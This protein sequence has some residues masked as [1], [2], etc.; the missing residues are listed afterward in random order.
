MSE[1][2]LSRPVE[3]EASGSF[4]VE[5][6][7]RL[8]LETYVLALT[9]LVW[10]LLAIFSPYFWTAGN[11]TNILRQVSIDAILAFGSLFP[12]ILAGIDLSVGSV[13]GLSGVVFSMLIA[14]AGQGLLVAFIATMAMGVVIGVIN[15]WAIDR[16]GIPPFIVTLAGLQGYRGLA[17]LL[18]GG[19]TI[20]GMPAGLQA[21][22]LSSVAHV[23]TLFLLMAVIGLGAHFLLAYTRLG[24]YMYAIGSNAEAA[25]RVGI[26]VIHV[27]TVA[28]ALAAGFATLSGLLLVARLSMGSPTAATG[29]ELQAIAAAV[30]G[31]ASLFGGRGTILGCFIGALLFTTIG[32]GANLLGVNSFWQMVIEGLLI[33]FV[34]YFDNLQKRRQAGIG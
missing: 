17:L 1:G 29:S 32:N 25:R 13:A 4:L 7:H 8:P 12:I 16:L 27:T 28:Y 10:V 3:E 9:V 21:F 14:D 26:R 33:A 19:M 22:S 30:V 18:S 6:Q 23:P 34:V 5:L 2:T 20:S 31:G 15:G 24:R 11:I